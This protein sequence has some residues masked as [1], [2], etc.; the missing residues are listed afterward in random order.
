MYN[1]MKSI[2]ILC[3]DNT[4]CRIFLLSAIFFLFLPSTLSAQ[5]S[6]VTLAVKDVTLKELLKEIEKK[7]DIRFSYIDE[8][9]EPYKH[10]T[11]EVTNE[12]VKTLLDNLLHTRNL[13]YVQTG[14]TIA[15]K[16]KNIAST[17]QKKVKGIVTDSNNEPV[18][19]A[20]I[21]IK[22]TT[23]GV[24]TNLDGE[25]EI[26]TSDDA[27]L[28]VS[29]IGFISQD[30][31]VKGKNSFFIRLQ[32]DLQ[33]L[34]EVVVVGYGTMRKNDLTGSVVRADLEALQNSPNVSIAQTLKGVVPGLNVGTAAKAGDSPSISIRGQNSISGTTDPLIVLDG[35]IYR[36]N[37]SDINP[38][39]VESIDVLKDASSAA[40][41]GSQSANGVILITTKTVKQMSKP[42]IE[43][44]GSI[45]FQRSINSS[46]KPLGREG[47]LQMVTDSHMDKSRLWPDGTVN[48]DYDITKDFLGQEI[49]TGYMQ[50]TDTDWYDLMTIDNPYIQNHN[51]SVRGK[52]ELSSYFLSF[53]VSDQ[54][55][56][57]KNDTYERY[58]I[59]INLDTK[60]TNWLSVGTQSFFTIGDLSGNNPNFYNICSIAPLIASHDENGEVITLPMLG[61]TNYLLL[62]DNP[63]VEKRYNLT[64][65]F[66]GI[67]N[68]PF[69]E[70]LSYRANYSRN[71]TFNKR[72]IF[73]QYANGMQGAAQKNNSSSYSWTFDNIV[74][75][76][77]T[78]AKHDIN[79]TFVYGVERQGYENTDAS[80]SNFTDMTLGYN[81]LG[82]AQSDLNKLTSGAWE[83]S[84]LYM[85][86]R[87]VYSYDSKYILTATLRRDG[88]SGFGTNNKFAYFPS[89]AIAWRLS[90]EKFVKD[91]FNWLNSLKLRLS[92][93]SNGN[94]TVGRYQ[95][96]ATMT[97][98]TGYVYG[99]GG[100]PELVQ[101]LKSMANNGLK[102]ETTT[103]L[104]VGVDFSLFN[105]RLYGDYEYYNS[106][107]RNLIY[108]VPIPAM[109][110]FGIYNLPTNIGKL[111]NYGHE[112]SLGGVPVRS[113]DFEWNVSFNFSLN[114][115]KVVSILG[116]DNNGDGKED[117]LVSA[118]IFIGQPLG[119]I[120]DY[121]IIGMWQVEDYKNGV[122]PE[123]FTYGHYK[124]ADLDG[125]GKYTADKDRQILGSSEP[126]YRFNI[127]N[128][129]KYKD[130][131][132]NVVVNSVQGGKNRYLGRPVS[133]FREGIQWNYFEFDYWTPDNPNAKYRQP[134][135]YTQSL[136]S[137][138][139]PYVSRS[140][141][142]LQEL[143]LSYNLPSSLLKRI[144]VNRAKVYV[145]ATNL[146]TI[147]GW[148]G[149]DPEAGLGI[150]SSIGSDGYPPTKNFTIGV[151]FEF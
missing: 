8:I 72:F 90:E 141:V 116:L 87:L 49:L 74:T 21:L 18:I 140:F 2:N 133:S 103:S 114:R 56:L 25:F 16:A 111:K 82:A 84:S 5:K 27:V 68:F 92:Y 67:I 91:K 52:N 104:N 146:F 113:K 151:N 94:R 35:I 31:Q 127:R 138:F 47:Y 4:L 75:Y 121:K 33:T 13:E 42:I 83:E 43:Y 118:G 28:Q 81:Y 134:G 86:G 12:S 131:E 57:I 137:K 46:M 20:S 89:A 38:S 26:E 77:R 139:S 143:S 36:G 65:N 6:N 123:G 29:Y 40:I 55:N 98:G 73:D 19:G 85:M 96:L 63:D 128:S 80:A 105:N 10:I 59:R 112:F 135:S 7:S 79:A 145:S 147:T 107:T 34:E 122:I 110:G 144:S 61:N 39:D 129:L 51:L 95:T 14:N 71:Y 37:M 124:I 132:L 17:R 78:F 130:L 117:D 62:L 15:I 136:G 23:I 64:G 44:S 11:L 88:F 150:T 115:N 69:V 126:A 119:A 70:G 149:W 41:Y 3:K 9:V 102:W 100:S 97:S 99:D 22:G 1:N 76:K 60:I 93:G 109:N 108:N 125:D 66:Y 148:D 101:S 48:P 30:I 45:S 53:G 142:R 50:G 58:N 106:K 120:Y 24:I 32:E 54:K